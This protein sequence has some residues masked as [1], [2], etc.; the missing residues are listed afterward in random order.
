[1]V[2][3]FYGSKAPS[4]ENR[5]FEME[6]QMLES[7]GHTVEMFVRTSDEIRAQGAW[8]AL[9]GALATPWNPWMARTIRKQVDE[10]KPDIVHIH[11][12]FPLI[13]PAIMSAIGRRAK[14]VLTLHNYRTLCP[15]A[16]PM[17]NN[18]VCTLCI[19]GR[20]VWPALRFGCYRGSRAATLPLALSVALHRAR[21]TWIRDVDAFIAL[22]AFQREKMTGAG[23]PAEKVYVKPNFYPGLPKIKAWGERD[24]AVVYVGRL[25]AE[26]GVATLVAAWRQWGTEAPELRLVGDGPM[27]DELVEAA[28][29]FPVRFLGQLS[30]DNTQQEMEKAKLLVL[31]SEWFETFGMVVIEAFA[32]GTPVAVSKLGALPSIVRE[33][34]TGVTFP[35]ADPAGLLASVRQAWSD[36]GLL[37]RMGEAARKEFED[38]YTEEANYRQL[39]EIY[40]N[41]LAG[42]TASMGNETGVGKRD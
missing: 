32:H 24:T 9:R 42:K 21:G 20:T 29:G 4:G 40:E 6:R 19:D 8:G 36:D 30:R 2:H 35:P 13:S 39:M 28:T 17:R 14:K 15:A 25:S 38:K 23:L 1:M 18:R 33:G 16:I 3:N 31:P 11:N 22:S 7:R 34:V 41:V 27:R 12:T 26:K 5:V 10:F 37:A